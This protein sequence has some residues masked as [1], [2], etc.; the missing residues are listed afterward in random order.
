M[1][2]IT[3]L[4][5]R[6]VL[7]TGADTTARMIA[8]RF[9]AAGAS[10]F[11]CD[12]RQE[13]IDL[14]KAANPRMGAAI[15]DVSQEVD[16]ER[17]IE[18]AQ[19]HMGGIDVLVNVVGV[20]GPAKPVEEISLSEWRSTLSVN[21]DGVFLTIRA[22]V[23]GMKAQGHGVIL[24]ISTASTRT[25]PPNRSPYVAS[26]CAVEGLTRSLARELGPH[27]VR[28]NAILPGGINSARMDGI[29]QRLADARGVGLEQARRE[30][31]QFVSMRSLIESEEIA[32]MALFLCSDQA[33]HVSG[34]LI[35]VD[36]NSEWEE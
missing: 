32:E 16:V 29:F 11:T 31:L 34:Q 14:I 15:A 27:Q 1:S 5:G 28:V 21:L 19:A 4:E 20:P 10:V 23:A 24:N 33:R 3:G 22:V 7:L 17:L 8:E 25:L 2:M 26:K 35:A 12:I 9:A 6:R 13:A 18:A 36:G 30:A